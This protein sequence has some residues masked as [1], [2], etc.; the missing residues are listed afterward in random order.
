[1]PWSELKF[2][3]HTGRSLPQV[4]FRDPDWFFWACETSVFEGKGQLEREAA[5]LNKKARSIRIPSKKGEQ[6]VAN[7]FVHPPTGKFGR[8]QIVASDTAAQD[9]SPAIRK[10]VIDLSMPRQIA[11][12]DKL[13]CRILISGAKRALFGSRSTRMTRERCEDFF[14]TPANFRGRCR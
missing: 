14:N 4:I 7:Y 2:G 10:D 13:G 12:Y 6:L 8:M 9:S 1:M 3:K 5:E 11:P